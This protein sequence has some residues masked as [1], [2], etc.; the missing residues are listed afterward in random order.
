[1]DDG[2]Y[3]TDIFLIIVCIL[4]FRFEIMIELYRIFQDGYIYA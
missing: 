2:I 3:P 4:V 1:M